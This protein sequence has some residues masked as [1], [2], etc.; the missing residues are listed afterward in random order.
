VLTYA[1]ET[2]I[3]AK[4]ERGSKLTFFER[5]VYRRILV[6]LYENEKENWNVLTNKEIRAIVKRPTVM[7]TISK[8]RG[9]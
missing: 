5:K 9:L 8:D 6:A 2:C 3:L 7:G 1:T 4:R